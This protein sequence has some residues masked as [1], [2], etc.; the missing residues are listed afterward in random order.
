[1]C[2]NACLIT[3]FVVKSVISEPSHCPF[4][5]NT[6]IIFGMSTPNKGTNERLNTEAVSKRPQGAHLGKDTILH[7][8]QLDHPNSRKLYVVG[9]KEPRYHLVKH[10]KESTIHISVFKK[11]SWSVQCPKQS[12]RKAEL[13]SP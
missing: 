13:L 11:N 1:M 8:F 9:R 7:K 3:I 6:Q 10:A 2:I 5:N 12:S 4:S